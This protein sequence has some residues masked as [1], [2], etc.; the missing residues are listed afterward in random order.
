MFFNNR[1]NKRKIILIFVSAAAFLVLPSLLFAAATYYRA[2][3]NTP[4]TVDEF[5]ACQE[6]NNACANDVF[7]PTKTETEWSNFRTN[8]PACVSF[9]SCSTCGNG[10]C[11][12]GESFW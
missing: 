11:D 10:T 8:K 6:T 7:I 4:V 3:A 9:T 2:V 12:A 1:K 5:S